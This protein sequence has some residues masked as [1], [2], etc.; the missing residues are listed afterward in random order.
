MWFLGKI[1]QLFGRN[2]KKDFGIK[3][4][5]G[6]WDITL[7]VISQTQ[8]IRIN[9]GSRRNPFGNKPKFIKI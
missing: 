2:T 7:R 9:G 8:K 5:K 4:M 1:N 6:V 3:Q